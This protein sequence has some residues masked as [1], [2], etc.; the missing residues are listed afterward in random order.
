MQRSLPEM[1]RRN[2]AKRTN[3]REEQQV[4]YCVNCILDLDSS[5]ANRFQ[6]RIIRRQLR[7]LLEPIPSTNLLICPRCR[8]QQLKPDFFKGNKHYK[9]L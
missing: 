1:F 2:G 7:V 5:D 9:R 8:S 3:L 4:Y 6:T